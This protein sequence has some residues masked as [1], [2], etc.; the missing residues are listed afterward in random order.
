MTTT[1]APVPLSLH[2]PDEPADKA[3]WWE[4]VASGRPMSEVV[5]AADGIAAW[6]WHR[7]L[8]LERAGIERAAFAAM[9]NAYRRELWLWLAGERLWTQCCSGLIGRIQRRIP[10]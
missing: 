8:V 7:W 4:E 2:L 1:A 3:R 9:V 6:L 10:G 5:L